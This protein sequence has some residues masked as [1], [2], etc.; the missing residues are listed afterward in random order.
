MRQTSVLALV[1]LAAFAVPQAGSIGGQPGSK[2]YEPRKIVLSPQPVTREEARTIFKRVELAMRQ[3]VQGME[4]VN[5]I[6][7][8][9]RQPITRSDIV[10]QM[11]RLFMMV[12]PAFRV[13]PKRVEFDPSRVS[14]KDPVAKKRADNLITWGFVS[15]GGLLATSSKETMGVVEFGEAVGYF[16]ARV[17]DLTHTPNAKWSPELMP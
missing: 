11:D 4:S 8:R 12:K 10:L 14:I 3:V 2:P 5:F 16:L 1:G 15:K 17:A 9:G 7:P 13:T 6:E